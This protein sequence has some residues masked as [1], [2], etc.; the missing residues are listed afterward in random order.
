MNINFEILE[1]YVLTDKQE[2]FLKTL[3][4]GTDPYFF[5]TLLHALNLQGADIKAKEIN[6]LENYKKLETFNYRKIYSR[7]LFYKID[8]FFN[9]KKKLVEIF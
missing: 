3:I 7:Y 5:L 2:E 4:S 8:K 1:K 6:A 9:S